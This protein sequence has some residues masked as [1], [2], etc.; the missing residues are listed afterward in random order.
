MAT[1]EQMDQIKEDLLE[2]INSQMQLRNSELQGDFMRLRQSL[3]N[4]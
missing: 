1:E 3:G 2:E 4:Q